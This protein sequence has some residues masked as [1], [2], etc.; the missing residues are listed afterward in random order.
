MAVLRLGYLHHLHV[1]E[2]AIVLGLEVVVTL[3]HLFATEVV[4][5]S[6]RVMVLKGAVHRGDVWLLTA[7]LA[8]LGGRILGCCNSQIIH[9]IEILRGKRTVIQLIHDHV[10]ILTVLIAVV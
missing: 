1:V 2:V 6:L 8:D 7:N 3:D 9:L 4:H 10:A 5:L